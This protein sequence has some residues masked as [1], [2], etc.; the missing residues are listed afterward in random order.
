MGYYEVGSTEEEVRLTRRE[1]VNATF[2]I[3]LVFKSIR[4]A[5]TLFVVDHMNDI[6]PHIR[7]DPEIRSDMRVLSFAMAISPEGF[8]LINL[9]VEEDYAE[10][11]VRD[12]TEEPIKKRMIHAS[13]FVYPVWQNFK[14]QNIEL[15]FQDSD[16][17]LVLTSRVNGD[18]CESIAEGEIP[19]SELASESE[20][21][22]HSGE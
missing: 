22:I 13:Q 3:A 2:K 15:K 1:L 16:G 19:F 14:N 18:F 8:E 4:T 6:K 9:K 7:E 17:N 11:V 12:R 21:E 10:A 20:F 5:R